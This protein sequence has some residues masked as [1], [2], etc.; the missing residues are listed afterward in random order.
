MGIMNYLRNRAGVII[1]AIVGL[2]I[3]AFLVSDA[4][5]FGS[6][7]WSDSR[8]EVGEV[9]GESIH[10]NDF[11][12]KV[13]QASDAFKAQTRQNNINPSMMGY[14]VDNAWNETLSEIILKK[15]FAKLGLV[16]GEEE[17]FDMVQG[18]E[19]APQILRYFSDPQT[20]LFDRA[21]LIQFLKTIDQDPSGK[22]K[23]Q[24]LEL[25]NGLVDGQMLY[26]YGALVERGLYVT[27]IEAKDQYDIQK[28]AK[29]RYV[30]MDYTSISDQQAQPTDQDYEDYYNENKYKFKTKEE[31]RNIQ[32]VVFDASPT[33]ADSLA[34]KQQLITLRE[35]LRTSKNDSLFVGLHAETQ[36]PL[37]YL[38][39]GRLEPTLDSLLFKSS[40]GSIL[41]PIISRGAYKIAKL[42]DVKNSPDS[43]KA[44]HIL[45][46]PDAAGGLEKAKKQAD[47]IKTVLAMGGDFESIAKKLSAD[48]GSKEK[49]GDLGTFARGTMV[50]VF[51]EACFDGKAGDYKI[52][53]SQFGVHIIHIQLQKGN[54]KV[55]KAAIVDK[56]IVAS[57][58][59]Q[60]D[61]YN[62]VS[63]FMSTL[64]E[65]NLF[66]SKAKEAR[67]KVEYAYLQ[68]TQSYLPDIQ[69]A[70]ELVRWAYKAKEGEITTDILELG[71][72]YVVARLESVQPKGYK[73]LESVK[74]QIYFE[75]LNRVKGKILS[76]KAEEVLAN[77]TKSI[78]D[79][80]KKMG[81]S[82]ALL[83]SV[84]IENP[85]L[86]GIAREEYLVGSFFGAPK[87][88]ISAPIIGNRGVYVYV[89]DAINTPTV[90][91]N[92]Q[93]VKQ[94]LSQK[95]IYGVMNQSLEALKSLSNIKDNRIKFY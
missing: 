23:K 16:V 1:V 8:T 64:S 84:S 65:P 69:Q 71:D 54:S 22:A 28:T 68:A 92:S 61:A 5:R 31:L 29:A 89:L 80:A 70:R 76:K 35:Q 81:K 27:D 59:T 41:G 45:I 20:G 2:A 74:K 6:A 57:A 77:G 46:N 4:V 56:Q 21:K 73:T 93:F 37:M 53:T 7:F 18:K 42:I 87:G 67:L 88:R 24:W 50:P 86:S 14:V 91:Y 9:A 49:G 60:K 34:L 52:V 30:N 11:S 38:S 32:Y 12:Q 44:R 15:E 36:I 40:K 10:I 95:R 19:P 75:V 63:A 83:D 58:Q 62:A 78:E 33:P 39:K 85:I 47:S 79:L 82:I 55:V 25:E 66:A 94:D 26:K 90:V 17:L 43:V 72:K 13:D 48:P 51:E 3:V